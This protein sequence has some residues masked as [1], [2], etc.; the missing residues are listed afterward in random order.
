ME[1]FLIY[2]DFLIYIEFISNPYNNNE[3]WSLN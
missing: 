3:Y 1:I 2:Y